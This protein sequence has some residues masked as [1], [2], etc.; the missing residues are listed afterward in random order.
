[1]A[2][3]ID[4]RFYADGSA[5]RLREKRKVAAWVGECIAAE[6]YVSGAVSYIFC[7]PERHLEINRQYLGHDYATDVITFDYSDL[8]AGVVSGDIFIDP[9]TVRLNASSYGVT[10]REEMLRVLIHGVLHLCGYKDKTAAEQKLMRAKE[11]QCLSR[12]NG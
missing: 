9:A 7:S 8:P 3:K 4:V 1:M 2:Q 6:G 5:Y 10:A 12:W 11:D